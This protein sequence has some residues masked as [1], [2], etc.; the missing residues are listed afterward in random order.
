M[1]TL[2]WKEMIATLALVACLGGTAHA[3]QRE[4]RGGFEGNGG[5]AVRVDG[6][7]VLRDFMS[8]ARL[9]SVPNNSKFLQAYP[10]LLQLVR[11]LS[12]ANPNFAHAVWQDLLQ[13]KIWVTD[14]D[15]PLLPASATALIA[16]RAE[17]QIAIRNGADIIISL[18]ALAQVRDKEYVFLHESIHGLMRGDG[19]WHHEKVRSLV[20]YLRENRGKYQPEEVRTLFGKMEISYYSYSDRQEIEG[21]ILDVLLR[22]DGSPEFRCALFN[23][24]VRSNTGIPSYSSSLDR[25][26]SDRSGFFGGSGSSREDERDPGLDH[27]LAKLNDYSYCNPKQTMGKALLKNYPRF[28]Q[29]KE[30]PVDT[31][32]LDKTIIIFWERRNI[33]GGV[34]DTDQASC[35][36]YVGAEI[37]AKFRVAEERVRAMNAELNRAKADARAVAET[38]PAKSLAILKVVEEFTESPKETA[39][40]I[41][42]SREMFNTNLKRCRARYPGQF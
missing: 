15:L 36:E 39:A 6:N 11:E 20:R 23:S 30:K 35:E 17:V 19:P 22:A 10:E 29:W 4:T 1:R 7:L 8:K 2:N 41:K 13:A 37:R 40:S 42:T 27:S 33:F 32:E 26:V 12:H 38:D 5:D 28:M 31:Y 3:E 18:P 24:Y 34:T 14:A 21:K 16:G 9:D 25:F